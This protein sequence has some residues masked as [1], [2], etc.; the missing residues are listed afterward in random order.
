M[1]GVGLFVANLV[2]TSAKLKE[3]ISATKVAIPVQEEDKPIV[4][5]PV[6]EEDQTKEVKKKPYRS[7][8]R[9]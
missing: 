1:L 3:E 8:P 4:E 7:K 5:S 6:H 9:T 2:N